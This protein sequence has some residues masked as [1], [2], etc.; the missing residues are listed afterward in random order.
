MYAGSTYQLL[1]LGWH[2]HHDNT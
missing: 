2:A 1:A